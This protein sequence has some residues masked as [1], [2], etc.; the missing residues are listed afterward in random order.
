M[1]KTVRKISAAA[2]NESESSRGIRRLSPNGAPRTPSQPDTRI[3][4][5]YDGENRSLSV[6]ESWRLLVRSWPFIA[7]HRELVALK[8]AIAVSSLVFF[9][10]T[11][12]PLKIVIDNVV[13][14]IPPTGIVAHLLNAIGAR[15]GASILVSV[16]VFLAIAGLLIGVVGSDTPGLSTEVASGG[17]D[18]AGFTANQANSGWSLWNGLLGF[19]ETRVTLD[20]TQRINQ[21]VRVALYEKFLRSPLGLYSD[22]KLGDAVFR[23]MHDSASVGAV[24]YRGVLAPAM[25]V[26]GFLMTLVIIT[27]E[28]SNQPLIPIAAALSLPIVAI[29][30]G[31]FGRIL[32]DQAQR[33]R[34]R[35]SD[36]MAAF[37]E[38][39]AHVQLIKAYGQEQR[40]SRAVDSVSWA[41]FAAT[42]RIL[43]IIMALVLVV[44]PLTMAV[45]GAAVYH[46]GLDVIEGKLSR[47]DLVLLASYAGMMAWPMR[48]IG[49]TW[50]E[51]QGPISGLR[52]I[53]SVL[54]TP[55]EDS[56][57]AD[58]GTAPDKIE[59]VSFRDV[60][61]GYGF[62]PVLRD[63]NFDLH[64]GEIVG[65]AGPSGAGKSTLILSIP[66]FIE[67]SAGEIK[68]DGLDT[69]TVALSCLR[70]R[71]GF[72][73]QQEA[74]FSRSLEDNIKYGSP[75]VSDSE[76]HAA[77][78][79]AGA[80]EFI[81][82]MP[83][84]YATMLGRRG[85]RLSVGQKQRIA[86]ARA[87]LRKPSMLVLDEPTAP[88]DPDSESAIMNTLRRLANE[89]IVLIVA[90][91]PRTLASCDR[92]LFV[93]D[94]TLRADGAHQAL[95]RTCGEYRDYLAMEADEP[96]D[97]QP[98]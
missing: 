3:A 39:I 57:R 20:L 13:S 50:A 88:L 32:R 92:V 71:I 21:D 10:L 58:E 49:A 43:A 90:H 82:S 45:V 42:L 86:I 36:V 63:V 73:F 60:S 46:L 80:A 55:A 67:P 91:R 38:R 85:A 8:C 12:W 30:A 4:H 97:P 22:Q 72:V 78:R 7:A 69:R 11:P 75:N 94:G 61:V 31:A 77:A 84:K 53:F 44:A 9:V 18:Q 28:F 5:L 76:V 48:V 98:S 6:R 62:S 95:I 2:M 74:L 64:S 14:Q 16:V 56:R 47:G 68:I 83:Q 19:V 65:V 93:C 54:D 17:L 40:E 23:V 52:R 37:E 87:L 35:G 59:T 89:R 66:R 81:E 70:K 96:A 27:S 29:G 24:F 51:L 79:E 41:S 25:S 26:V 15:D 33:M 34:E 1:L